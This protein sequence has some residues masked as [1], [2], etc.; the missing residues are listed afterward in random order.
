MG[1]R[2]AM[3]EELHVHPQTV[4]YRMAQ[5]RELFGSALDDPSARATLLLALA[6]GPPADE[7]PVPGSPTSS[8]E[9][10][11]EVD[12]VDELVVEAL[13]EMA[14]PADVP[15]RID[16]ASAWGRPKR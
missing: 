15:V 4:R 2:Q 16:A 5:L 3:A 13:D 14:D 8:A 12:D 1:N 11:D 9:L 7:R 6:W 10:V